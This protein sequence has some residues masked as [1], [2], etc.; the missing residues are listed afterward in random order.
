MS[1]GFTIQNL[2]SANHATRITKTT[3]TIIDHVLS[4]NEIKCSIDL[5][6]NFLTDHKVIYFK[7]ENMAN[8]KRDTQKIHRNRNKLVGWSL[9]RK[10]FNRLR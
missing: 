7:V 3:P 8:P 6:D 9:L 2:L 5:F 4:N 10:D 1:N